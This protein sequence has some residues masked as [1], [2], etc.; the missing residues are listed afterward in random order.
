MAALDSK[1]TEAKAVVWGIRLYKTAI[2][3]FIGYLP[4]MIALHFL[5][6]SF[7]MTRVEVL[8]FGLPMLSRAFLMP[9]PA[10]LLF[11]LLQLVKEYRRSDIIRRIG[12]SYDNLGERL[13]TAMEYRGTSNI[14]VEDL[15]SDVSRRMDDVES[16]T[17]LDTR[18]L[19]KRIYAVI[20]LAFVLL[21]TIVLDLRS[22]A[23]DSLDFILSDPD[24]QNRISDVAG[25]TG[26]EFDTLMGDR[27]EQSNL[28]GE[29]EEKLGAES[30]GERPGVSEG[31]LPGTGGG[32][33]ADA[34]E[35]IYG[36]ASAA[37]ILGD[38]VDFR[39]HPE[40]GGEIEI[41]ET[42]G[43]ARRNE[44]NL[45]EVQ[46]AEECEE[47]VIGPEH[48]EVVRRYFEKILPET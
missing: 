18:T 45:E 37:N 21:T 16:S 12:S 30:G 33:G 31:P 34:L 44:F 47:C 24:I 19:S 42:G 14:I 35:D 3:F 10:A 48:E 23:F 40:Y 2:D 43:T 6:F 27:W 9:L 11:A 39:L 32:V 4:V 28:T 38:D 20:I 13:Q 26:S 15:M 1:V 8:G 25:K 46:S 41:R 5:G 36:E 17:F 22:V 29:D 7:H